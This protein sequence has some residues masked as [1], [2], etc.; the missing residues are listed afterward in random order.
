MML[1]ISAKDLIAPPI[2]DTQL[3][4]NLVPETKTIPSMSAAA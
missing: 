4:E 3:L 1:M 2:S